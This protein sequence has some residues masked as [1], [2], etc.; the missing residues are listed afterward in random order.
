MNAPIPTLPQGG[1]KLAL[2]SS[3]GTAIRTRPPATISGLVARF[4]MTVRY[5]VLCGGPLLPLSSRGCLCSD[6]S[7]W[8][9]GRPA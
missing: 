7:A 6:C 2:A 5:C 1:A 8:M 3:N 9:A 4:R